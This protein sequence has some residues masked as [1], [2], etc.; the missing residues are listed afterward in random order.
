VTLVAAGV[1]LTF[2]AHDPITTRITWTV[3]VSRIIN[4]RCINCHAKA[5]AVDLSSYAQ[6]RPWAKAIRNQVLARKMPPWGAVKGFGDFRND[7]SLT[8]LEMEMLTQWVE[9]GAPEGDQAYLPKPA[10]VATAKPPAF[11]WRPLPTSIQ[12]TLTVQA[13]RASGPTEVSAYLPDGTVE[14]L[15]Y[16]RDPQ[17]KYKQAYVF[18]EPII[19]PAGTKFKLTGAPVEVTG[20]LNRYPATSAHLSE[21]N[22]R[23][24]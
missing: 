20:S 5:S 16:I 9:G 17:P 6:A 15:L 3:E 14:H 18:R 8:P 21:V 12:G 1:L 24:P 19:L 22:H 23:L 7:P 13:I 11:Q 2:L 10:S 4:R